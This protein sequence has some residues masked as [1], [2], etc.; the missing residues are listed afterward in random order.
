MI[1][2]KSRPWT[3][4]LYLLENNIWSS[5]Y[6]WI[7][8]SLYKFIV[9]DCTFVSPPPPTPGFLY[10]NPNAKGGAFERWLGPVGGALL[11]GISVLIKETPLRSLK[12]FCAVSSEREPRGSRT[13][14]DTESAGVGIRDCAA[15]GTVSDERCLSRPV[16]G[17]FVTAA[18]TD[19]DPGRGGNSVFLV[20][21]AECHMMCPQLLSPLLPLQILSC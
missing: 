13:S 6:S 12:P 18:P 17:T 2:Y 16:G 7:I 1:T 19:W 15:S 9:M 3:V 4:A 8:F 14:L 20:A 11:S 10:W 5:M 21:L